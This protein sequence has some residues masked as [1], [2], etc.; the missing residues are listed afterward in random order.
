VSQTTVFAIGRWMPLH[1]G[2]KQFLV[3]LATQ[4]D[5][6]VIGIGSCYENGTPCNCIPAVEREKL[7]LKMLHTEGLTNVTVIPVQDRPTFE[8]WID[9]VCTVC[10]RFDVT[11]FCTGNKEDILDVM[12]QMGITLD[13][14]MINPED[15]SDF[16]F[17]ATDIRNAIL[18]GET[19]KLDGMIPA[20]IKPMVLSQVAREIRMANAG[21]GQEFIPGR[22]TVDTV[23]VVRNADNNT[24]SVLIGRRQAHKID[25]PGAWAIPGSAIEEFESPI[26]AAT[27]SFL[28]ETGLQVTVS[29]NTE[30]PA[31]VTVDSL[32]GREAL[33]HFI[34]IYASPDERINGTRGGGSQCF[35]ICIDDDTDSI[36]PL[37]HSSRDL[38]DLMFIDVNDVCHTDFAFDQKRMIFDTLDRLSIPYDN[39][40]L[41]QACDENGN[42]TGGVSRADAHANGILHAAS[43][44]FIYKW[45]DDKLMILL[46]RRSAHKDS[47]PGMLDTSSAGHMEFGSDFLET[48]QKELFE[49]LGLTVDADALTPLFMQ[50]VHLDN[51]FHHKRFID[52]EV[53]MVYALELNVDPASLTLQPAEVS[54]AV[55]M[56]ADE[57]LEQIDRDD[58]ELCMRPDEI[59]RVIAELK[60]RV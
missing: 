8:E 40:E 15:G 60:A 51:A 7:L 56:S 33:M 44:T 52:N 5:R 10:R 11:H 39:G 3:K 26:N 37:L 29:D 55:W 35:A 50:T 49:E 4:F 18:N 46:Q 14:D 21:E 54:E 1:L 6:L 31:R 47:Y 16:P 24:A 19:D 36:L 42:P 59:K 13:V 32:G 12:E 20:E 2:H 30:E 48:A 25:F 57:I 45:D 17:H 23:L 34:G 58:T 53:N 9:D 38:D 28:S 22:Q 41:L 43:H 27:R